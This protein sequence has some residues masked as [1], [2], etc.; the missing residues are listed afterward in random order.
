MCLTFALTIQLRNTML[1]QIS[2]NSRVLT[3]PI[4][5]FIPLRNCIWFPY[6]VIK[7]TNRNNKMCPERGTQKEKRLLFRIKPQ[8]NVYW[9][10]E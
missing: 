10:H 7:K 3:A 6:Q 2:L 1:P 4:Y 5:T 8:S 9:N